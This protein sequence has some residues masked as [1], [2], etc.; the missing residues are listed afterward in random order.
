MRQ[1]GNLKVSTQKKG[2]NAMKRFLI[3]ALVASF[4][5]SA[6]VA[7]AKEVTM[8]GQFQTDWQWTDN[9][10]FMEMDEDNSSEDDFTA[11]QRIRQYF[12]YVESEN[13]SGTLAFQ[14]DTD[15][16]DP[17]DGGQYATDGNNFQLKRGYIDF[18]WPGTS[19]NIRSGL[20]GLTMPSAV[21]GSPL[22]DDDVAGIVASYPVNDNVS[23]VAGWARLYDRSGNGADT[24]GKNSHDEI[25]AFTVIVPITMDGWSLTPYAFYAAMGRDYLADNGDA[26]LA[27][28]GTL[29]GTEG[30]NA[31]QYQDDLDAWW[32]GG[33]FT[34]NA[35]DPLNFGA[36]L[37][38]GSID[39]GSNGSRAD[40]EGWFFTAIATYTMDMVT[41]GIFFAYGTGEDDDPNNGS[42]AFPT[43][44]GVY[45]P[46]SFGFDGSSMWK[47]N[48]N[49]LTDGGTDY[50]AMVIG[51]GLYGFSFLENVSH[52]LIVAYGV[53]TNDSDLTKKWEGNINGS[54]GFQGNGILFTDEDSFW[55]VDFNT[56]YTMYEALTAY[57]EIGYIDADLDEDAHPTISA[58]CSELE[59]AWKLAV[60]LKYNY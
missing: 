38:Y 34:L 16:G 11:D 52:D 19:L 49:L 23:V 21:A 31:T 8:Q 54:R 5:L 47:S 44:T 48:D 25:D 18:N 39:G 12:N 7:S 57:L 42:E 22:W 41:P 46:T 51:G 4:V 56:K 35:F 20:Q 59:A 6:G 10:N 3:L 28:T 17:N 60:G 50:S 9:L 14:F 36:D 33:S 58:A 1:Q 40:R 29:P 37:L 26:A 27:N 53:G 43:L 24:A 15:W 32:L 30:V 2:R 13:L 45:A 55:E